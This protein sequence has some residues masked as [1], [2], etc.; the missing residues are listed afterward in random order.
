MTQ[1]HPLTQLM[2]DYGQ[3]AMMLKHFAHVTHL[4]SSSIS[5]HFYLAPAP[6][7]CSHDIKAYV[8][9]SCKYKIAIFLRVVTFLEAQGLFLLPLLDLIYLVYKTNDRAE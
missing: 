5:L 9:L 4:R 8:H 2:G 7:P 1:D 3:K 6:F